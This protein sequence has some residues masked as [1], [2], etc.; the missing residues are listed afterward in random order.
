MP[1]LDF[2][3]DE[4]DKMRNEH[5]KLLLRLR[6][7]RVRAKKR[8]EDKSNE[9]DRITFNQSKACASISPTQELVTAFNK[10]MEELWLLKT[11]EV[12]SVRH[13]CSRETAGFVVKGENAFVHFK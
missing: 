8:E 12:G 7:Q 5:K 13:A 9:V 4:R 11:V 2:I 3:Q 6:K 1:L 10:K